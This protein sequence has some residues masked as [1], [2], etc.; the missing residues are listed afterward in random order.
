MTHGH[1]PRV[2]NQE[3]EGSDSI[4]INTELLINKTIDAAL[5]AGISVAVASAIK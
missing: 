3:T 4:E 1:A 5:T 2:R